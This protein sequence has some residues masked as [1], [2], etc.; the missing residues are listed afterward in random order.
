MPGPV[1]DRIWKDEGLDL[2]LMPY[3]VLATGN[4]T[5]I[6]EP[7]R[8]AETV[9]TIQNN[10][11]AGRYQIDPTQLHKWLQTKNPSSNAV[12]SSSL[13]S[14]SVPPSTLIGTS[15]ASFNQSTGS[16]SL[17]LPQS[18]MAEMTNCQLFGIS[19]EPPPLSLFPDSYERAIQIFA[20]SC[21][22]YCVVTFVLGIRD[23]HPDNIMVD[24]TGRLF[25]IDFGHI[26]NNRKKKFG[27]NRERAPFVLPEH[28][29]YVLARGRKDDGLAFQLLLKW[30]KLAYSKL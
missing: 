17:S 19:P 26:L 8:D 14:L 5:G 23:R 12:T 1:I 29:L 21:A 6:I 9:M 11:L 22:G 24:T 20:R 4:N 15:F 28:F 13:M 16:A 18:T 30:S 7:V 25:H 3:G 2:F 10:T 27:F